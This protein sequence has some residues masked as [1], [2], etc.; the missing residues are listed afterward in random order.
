MN[1][2]KRFTS[3]R[4]KIGSKE[5]SERTPTFIIAEAASNHMCN[6][7]L[8]KKMIDKVSEAGADAIKFQTY[9]AERL[10]CKDLRAYWKYSTGAK[11]QFEYYKNLDKFDRAEYKELFNYASKKKIIT[12][13]TPFDVES[14]SMLN[15]LGAPLFKIASCDIL[16]TR[17]LRHIAKFNKPVILSTGA[18]TLKEIEKSVNIIFDTGNPNLILMVCTLSYPT[19]NQNVNLRR[20]LTFKEEFPD[21]IIG[22]SDHSTPDENMIIPSL[23]AALGVKV[24][25]KHYTLDRNMSGSGHSFSIEP[26]DLRKM[27]NNIRLTETVLGSEKIK[28]YGVEEAARK[29]ARRSLVANRDIKKGKKIID[30]LIGIK[31]PGTGLSPDLIDRVVGRIAKC[32]IKKDH[33]I[34]FKQLK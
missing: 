27:V 10:V 15:D 18:A 5:I 29:N 17:L 6:M 19:D 11:S 13:S 25:E 26:D 4:I 23:A 7:K 16:D 30:S 8:A 14:A 1:Y 22:L 2:K 24:I 31:R 21:I 34:N 20:I 3:K 32:D 9:K 28:I 12:F 33:Q